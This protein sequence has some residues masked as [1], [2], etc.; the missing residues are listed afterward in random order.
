MNVLFVVLALLQ[1]PSVTLTTPAAP[2]SAVLQ[3]IS[4][5]T[6]A[7]LSAPGEIGK[8]L[9]AVRLDAVPLETVFEKLA[10]ATAGEW[11]LVDGEHRLRRSKSV[12]AAWEKVA[13]ERRTHAIRRSL[14]GIKEKLATLPKWNDQTAK[15]LAKEAW[16]AQSQM[17]SGDSS[18]GFTAFRNAE[19]RAPSGRTLQSI[20][21]HIDPKWLA[22]IPAGGRVV[23]SDRPTKVQLALPKPA[24]AELDGY[25]EAKSLWAKVAKA[26]FGDV[27]VIFQDGELSDPLPFPPLKYLVI[28]ERR[29]EGKH[30]ECHLVAIGADG[31]VVGRG[32][33]FLGL[34]RGPTQEHLELLEK[35]RGMLPDGSRL[36]LSPLSAELA[37]LA[38]VPDGNLG[39]T[40]APPKLSEELKTFW[41]HPE[42]NE[43]LSLLP[44]ELLIGC[45]EEANLNLIA[46][47]PDSTLDTALRASSTGSVEPVGWFEEALRNEE[48]VVEIQEGW[49]TLRP[50]SV[51][52]GRNAD[53]QVLGKFV[54][55][56]L[57]AGQ[58]TLETCSELAAGIG[59]PRVNSFA[60][61]ALGIMR[62]PSDALFSSEWNALRLL[63]SLNGNQIEAASTSGLAVDKLNAAQG[64]LLGEIVFGA[65]KLAREPP[66]GVNVD[67][68]RQSL[69]ELYSAKSE[70]TESLAEG[71]LR[72][73][74][75]L[76]RERNEERLFADATMDG[77]QIG[78]RA[79][80]PRWVAR[81]ASDKTGETTLL[82]VK[83]GRLR[84]LDFRVQLG[85]GLYRPMKLIEENPG[86]SPLGT[87]EELPEPWRSQV[88]QA[89][90]G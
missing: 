77:M 23:L 76:L 47:L 24:L 42:A 58:A 12:A 38:A 20:L 6:G 89:M 59:G 53:R 15:E 13:I 86:R 84:E 9:I 17:T 79:V 19:S 70:P 78:M 73:H 52:A 83:V 82:G 88:K 22:T 90:G 57:Q 50:S 5:Q 33:A 75:L 54:R 21:T 81:F 37:R 29:F 48:L 61:F 27:E 39:M 74:M 31:K 28:L 2:V 16:L 3:Q 55:S 18:S 62:V 11:A 26:Q 56:S 41:T 44:S 4:D 87:I 85:G 36:D 1:S 14:D 40:P 65:S 32:R 43:I 60:A 46:R 64:Q 68:L 80:S 35:V 66:P 8:E 69:N 67:E 49:L 25:F 72:S 10:S 51:A 71:L 30:I 7:R 34:E 63:G 45:A